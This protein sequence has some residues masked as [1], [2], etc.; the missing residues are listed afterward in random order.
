MKI[1]SAVLL[2]LDVNRLTDEQA[3]I[4]NLMFEF[5]AKFRHDI[6]TRLSAL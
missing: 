3:H 4:T 2:L 1:C 6:V 5:F